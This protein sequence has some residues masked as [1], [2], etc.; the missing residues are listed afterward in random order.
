MVV[1][2]FVSTKSYLYTGYSISWIGQRECNM[3][4]YETNPERYL[5]KYDI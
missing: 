4:Q 3:H 5:A 2:Y 1:I